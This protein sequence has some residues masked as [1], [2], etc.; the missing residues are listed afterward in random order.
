MYMYHENEDEIPAASGKKDFVPRA[1]G[2]GRTTALPLY[3][4]RMYGTK[5]FEAGDNVHHL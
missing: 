1:R 5:F 3:S 4:V 2:G